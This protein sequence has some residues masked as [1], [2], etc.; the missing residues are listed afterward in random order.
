MSTLPAE[1]QKQIE[2]EARNFASSNYIHA[3]FHPDAN[4][5]DIRTWPYAAQVS[6]YTLKNYLEGDACCFS[7]SGQFTAAQNEKMRKALVEIM[8]IEDN[9]LFAGDVRSQAYGI[10][11]EALKPT[12]DE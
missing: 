9:R 11:N 3:G 6:Y 2:Q 4:L 7:V 10:A 5:E 8:A 1:L 12:T